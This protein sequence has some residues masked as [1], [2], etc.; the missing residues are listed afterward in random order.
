M[1]TE[2]DETYLEYEE[3]SLNCY[4]FRRLGYPTYNLY[5][6]MLKVCVLYPVYA[7]CRFDRS[8]RVRT[9]SFLATFIYMMYGF[10]ILP[11]S[12]ASRTGQFSHDS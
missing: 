4:I 3:I 7:E 11:Q 12:L 10:E 2:G 5:K 1:E 9:K 6:P 8:S